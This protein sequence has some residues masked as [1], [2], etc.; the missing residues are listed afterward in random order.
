MFLYRIEGE[1]VWTLVRI[2]DE[3]EFLFKFEVVIFF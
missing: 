1:E 2:K 3:I